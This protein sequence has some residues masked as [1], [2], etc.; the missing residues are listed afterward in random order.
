[1]TQPS[2]ALC[3]SGVKAKNAQLEN[4]TISNLAKQL[5]TVKT[6]TKDGS[7][8][9]RTEAIAPSKGRSD[10]NTASTASVLILDADSTVDTETGETTE[11]APCPYKVHE[12][13][14]EAGINHLIYR[15][16]S[17]DTKGNR[18]RIV[19]KTNKPYSR[20]ELAQTVSYALTLCGEPIANVK[21]NCTWS[22]GSYLPRKPEGDTSEFTQ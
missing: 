22:Q 5:T 14:K 1:M 12:E 19:F 2:V 16:F 8:F 10:K 13:L 20:A 7:Y 11:G 6:G 3:Q 4:I 18:Y 15:S 17:H 9:L 21:E